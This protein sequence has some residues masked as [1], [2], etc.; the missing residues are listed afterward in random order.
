MIIELPSVVYDE[1]ARSGAWCKLP[2]PDHPK[3]CPNFPKCINERPSFQEIGSPFK[4]YAIIEEFDLKAHAGK[5]KEKHPNWSDRM[6][7]NLLYWQNGVRKRLKEKAIKATELV[8][9]K[10]TTYIILDIPEAHGVDVY[11][12]MEQVGVKIVP[13]PDHVIKVMLIGVDQID[14]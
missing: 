9:V 5:M 2:Y 12:T 13:R 3:G 10:G 11:K 8:A 1:R 6:C 14:G 4:W 7:R